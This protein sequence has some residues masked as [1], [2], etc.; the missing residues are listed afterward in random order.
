MT[1]GPYR[2]DL[3]TGSLFIC[4]VDY[5]QGAHLSDVPVDITFILPQ[6]PK[7]HH[8][9]PN[10]DKFCK[11]H[12]EVGHEIDSCFALKDDIKRLIRERYLKEYI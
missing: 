5:D 11:F 3:T 12:N 1:W 4:R 9:E 2:D 8:H 10:N 7:G 6:R